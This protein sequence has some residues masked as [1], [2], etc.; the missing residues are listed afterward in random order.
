MPKK[1]VGIIVVLGLVMAWCAVAQVGAKRKASDPRVEKL[2]KDMG[3]TYLIDDDGDFKMTNDVG[4]G[5]TQNVYALS[6]TVNLSGLEIRVVASP[7]FTFK[8]P[9]NAELANRLLEQNATVK[10][11][12]WQ[13]QKLGDEYVAVFSA[14]IAAETD[15]G[16][17]LTAIKAVTETADE[18]E[19]E[20]TSK[21]VF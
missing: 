13:T 2:L 9:M 4:G 5:R 15:S 10:L 16:T 17:L 14:Q 19:K 20:L 8:R 6:T 21:D 1:V 7:S 18:L 12:A 3:A 11:G